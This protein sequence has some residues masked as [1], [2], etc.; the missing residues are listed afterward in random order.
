MVLNGPPQHFVIGLVELQVM[1]HADLHGVPHQSGQG[2]NGALTLG[3]MIFPTNRLM[4]IPS[5]QIANSGD[6]NANAVVFFLGYLLRK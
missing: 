1:V 3:A 5:F 6:H 4:L 2:G